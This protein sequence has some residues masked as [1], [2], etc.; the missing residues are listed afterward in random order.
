[1][2]NI[3]PKALP[4]RRPTNTFKARKPPPTTESPTLVGTKPSHEVGT[5][6][7]KGPDGNEKPDA[8]GTYSRSAKVLQH[9]DPRRHTHTQ[10]HTQ[11]QWATEAQPDKPRPYYSTHAQSIAAMNARLDEDPK[12]YSACRHRDLIASDGGSI[13]GIKRRSRTTGHGQQTKS[14]RQ[15]DQGSRRQKN[16]QGT[17][18]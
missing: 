12:P 9:L 14:K 15:S 10:A 5:I 8:I 17:G 1:M 11:I 4:R 16:N 2:E 13:A 6:G 18:R 7:R 3:S